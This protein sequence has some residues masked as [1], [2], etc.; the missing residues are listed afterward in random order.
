MKYYLLIAAI[1]LLF[2]ACKPT[3]S[4]ITSKDAAVKKGIYTEPVLAKN[5][6]L[7]NKRNKRELVAKHVTPTPNQKQASKIND[8]NESDII[9]KN[10]DSNYLV[11]QLINS[12]SDN[13]GV[14]Y[15][16]GG[17]TPAGFD[18]SG[19]MYSTFKKYDIT[20]PRSSHEM[21]EVGVQ[22]NPEKAKKGDLIFFINRGQRRINHVG[23]IVEINGDEIK[24]IHSSTQSGVIISSLKESYYER[25]FK[26]INR[27]IE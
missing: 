2:T 17:T 27:I 20:L 24:F 21:A 4:I 16:A 19:L 22:I 8:Q 14:N 9:I 13:L 5:N 6:T 12:A 7:I 25:T 10:E 23:M 26:Q 3:S 1:L 11:E 15:R 18:C